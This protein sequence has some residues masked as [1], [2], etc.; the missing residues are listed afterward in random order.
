MV[1]NRMLLLFQ[2]ACRILSC[3]FDSG[4]PYVFPPIEHIPITEED[5]S[6]CMVEGLSVLNV[7]SRVFAL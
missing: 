2:I 1:S 3:R 5:L 4:C 6:N 7:V